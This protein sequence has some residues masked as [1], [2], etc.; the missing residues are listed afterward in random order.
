MRLLRSF[1]RPR[2]CWKLLP[3]LMR[4][5]YYER[6]RW[7]HW[8][9]W[10]R[11]FKERSHRDRIR[12]KLEEKRTQIRVTVRIHCLE[13]CLGSSLIVKWMVKGL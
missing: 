6:W 7:S 5:L 9:R 1:L 12:G 13:T 2:K 10:I 4:P 8:Q 3:L 11:G